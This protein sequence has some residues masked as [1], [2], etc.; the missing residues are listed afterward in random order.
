MSRVASEPDLSVGTSRNAADLSLYVGL[1]TIAFTVLYLLSDVLEV[2]QG[3]FS[4]L[5][6]CLTYAG[7]SSI[8]LFVIGLYVVQRPSIGRLGLL[9]ATGYAYAYVFFT[10]TVVYALVAGTRDY[11]ALA[12][13]FGVWMTIHGLVMVV[14]GIAFGIAVVRAGKL[15]SWTG[16]CLAVGVVAVAAASGL[17]T[18]ARTLAEALP[19][20]A[21]IGMGSVLLRGKAG[22]TPR[23]STAAELYH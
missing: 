1:A 19:A 17:P 8:P 3:D 13:V 11:S 23:A 12:N 20:A 16:V 21:F 2:I 22:P 5:R 9:G 18:L 14:G 10:S 6:L 4:T 15:P 7:E